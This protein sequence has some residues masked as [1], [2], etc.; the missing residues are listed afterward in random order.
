MKEHS[1]RAFWPPTPLK[2]GQ[3]TAIRHPEF[4]DYPL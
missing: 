4:I 2:P 1:C 3:R